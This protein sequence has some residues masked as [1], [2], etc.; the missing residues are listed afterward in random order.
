MKR[1]KRLPNLEAPKTASVLATKYHQNQARFKSEQEQKKVSPNLSHVNPVHER[2]EL[3]FGDHLS[4]DSAKN[5][6]P[7]EAYIAFMENAEKLREYFSKQKEMRARE[8]QDFVIRF[9]L[10]CCIGLAFLLLTTVGLYEHLTNGS[11][12]L[13]VIGTL[14]GNLFVEVARRFLHLNKE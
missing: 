3:D 5:N 12:T 1:K 2:N 10:V 14:Q 7:L 11:S 6:N 9:I 4:Q 13:L 8:T